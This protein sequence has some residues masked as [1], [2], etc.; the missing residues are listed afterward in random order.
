[1]KLKNAV[2]LSLALSPTL[3]LSQEQPLVS[4]EEVI[5]TQ[6][7][8]QTQVN[9]SG[10]VYAQTITD[11]NMRSWPSNQGQ[12]IQTIPAD[13]TVYVDRCNG[14]GWCE[15]IYDGQTGYSF[16]TYLT[17]ENDTDEVVFLTP[18]F[19]AQTLPVFE[20]PYPSGYVPYEQ[21]L[22]TP[23]ITYYKDPQD[24][25]LDAS[26]LSY[27]FNNPPEPIWLN[28]EVVVGAGV[29]NAVTTYTIPNTRYSYAN[30]ND[31]LVV[32]NPVDRAIIHTL[33]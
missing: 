5:T 28:G 18:E 14:D 9:V 3:A 7:E 17:L 12:V 33:D 22:G 6:V 19:T 13:A 32:I 29:P 1:M 30:I 16:G 27:V 11:L 31:T 4:Q 10:P 24:V 23:T 15:V 25:P 20:Y 2:A 8:T 26:V 21:T